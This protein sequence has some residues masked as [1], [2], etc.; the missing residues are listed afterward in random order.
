MIACSFADQRDFAAIAL[1]TTDE[2][3]RRSRMQA[4]FIQHRQ[5]PGD[6]LD[7][8][9]LSKCHDSENCFRFSWPPSVRTV[10]RASLRSAIEK[11]SCCFPIG[12]SRHFGLG[13]FTQN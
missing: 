12:S 8:S 2:L 6:V 5:L 4:Q 1:H 11:P 10:M 7:L 9:L 3:S 13:D